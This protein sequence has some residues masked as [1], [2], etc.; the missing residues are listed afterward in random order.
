MAER[1]ALFGGTPVRQ[2]PFPDWPV[3]GEAER[4]ALI[5]VL[6]SGNWNVGE[7]VAQFEEA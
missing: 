6:D 1:L 3:F 4:E 5:N 2:E 7:K